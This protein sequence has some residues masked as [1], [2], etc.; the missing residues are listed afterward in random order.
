MYIHTHIYIYIYIHTHI[1]IYTYVY[2]Y[3]YA[4]VEPVRDTP[5]DDVGGPVR[6]GYRMLG[7]ASQAITITITILYYTIL[8]Y[9]ILY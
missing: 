4:G 9:S 3:V 6:A 5:A 2:I 1:Y 8:Y 7:D